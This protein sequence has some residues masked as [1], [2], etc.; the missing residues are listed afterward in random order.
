MP[1]VFIT[2]AVTGSGDT[3][4]KSD[5]VPVTPEQIA[6]ECI[7]AAKAGAA[8]VHIHVRDPLTGKGSRQVGLYAE[9]VDR[10]RSSDVDVVL[11]LTAG[12]G[13]D[14]TFGSAEHPFPVDEAGT[15]MA[16]ATERLAHVKQLRPEICTLD[17]GTMNF[18][19]GDYIMTNSTATLKTMARQIQ[20][21]GVRPEIE[22]F[23]TGHLWQAK[24]LAAEGLIAEPAMI[25]LCMG[26]PWGA[27]P[28]INTLMAMVNNVPAGWTWSAFSLG[29]RQ[30]EYVALAA[31]AG[32]NIRVG[33][34]DNLYLGRGQTAS[35][36]DLVTRAVEILDRLGYGI[37][38]PQE[39]RDQLAV[40]KHG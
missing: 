16:G 18:G 14:L 34:E 23:D 12:M 6:N 2:C 24:S 7:A 36:G 19:E 35:N 8:V 17:C 26:V 1:S 33:L 4:N 38:G 3:V 27:P 13:G 37:K 5:K 31:I 28:D 32:G 9:V 11:N 15:D 25:Q 21:L 40:V 29:R 30:M 39:V 22:A 20:E 10:V